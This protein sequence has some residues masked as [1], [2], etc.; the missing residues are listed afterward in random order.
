VVSD[1]SHR[2]AP[3]QEALSV[4][5]AA[6]HP[7][8]AQLYRYWVTLSEPGVCAPLRR[9][10]DP[11]AVPQLLSH[12]WM[13]DIQHEPAF[14][15]RYRLLGTRV[16]QVLGRALKGQWLDECHPWA[17]HPAYLVR[18][19]EVMDTGI[20]SWRKG[21]PMFW[22]DKVGVIENV[23]LP[24]SEGGERVDYFLIETRFYRPDGVEM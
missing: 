12:L 24:M 5:T 11:I 10:F 7:G 16:E 6:W 19:R 22:H 9:R 18:Y 15:L 3:V 1:D 14:R 17:K 2:M 21:P 8:L 13:L 23:I 20:P 4:D